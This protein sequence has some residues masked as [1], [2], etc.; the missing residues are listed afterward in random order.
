MSTCPDRRNQFEAI[1]KE[2]IADVS[3]KLGIEGSTLPRHD[4]V[5]LQSTLARRLQCATDMARPA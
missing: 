3:D 4:E 2:Q 1:A 5:Q